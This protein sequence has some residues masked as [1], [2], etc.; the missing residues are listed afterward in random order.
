[1]RTTATLLRTSLAIA[2]EREQS[3]VDDDVMIAA[4]D[5]LALTQPSTVTLPPTTP[6]PPP[7]P[8]THTGTRSRK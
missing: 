1:V 4:I 2:H 6:E 7:K 8:R 3:F 5:D